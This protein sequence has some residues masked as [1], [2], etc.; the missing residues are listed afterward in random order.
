M[1]SSKYPL[2]LPHKDQLLESTFE[3]LPIGIAYA[4]ITGAFLQVNQV[5]ANIT[6]YTVDELLGIN[7][8]EAEL[9][10]YLSPVGAGPSGNS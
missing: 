4:D 5:F 8:R 7:F 2:S 3:L 6:G 10:Q 9:I 1:R